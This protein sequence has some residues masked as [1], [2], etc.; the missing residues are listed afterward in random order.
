MFKF[1]F[2]SKLFSFCSYGNDNL[3]KK[4]TNITAKLVKIQKI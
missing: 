4:L 3:M 2:F 1:F